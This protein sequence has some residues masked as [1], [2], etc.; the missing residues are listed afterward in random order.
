ML[1]GLLEGMAF[2]CTAKKFNVTKANIKVG[3]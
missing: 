2:S 3:R 1:V